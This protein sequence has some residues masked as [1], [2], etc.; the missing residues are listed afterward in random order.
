[1]LITPI[2]VNSLGGRFSNEGPNRV[3]IRA[4]HYSVKENRAVIFIFY[5]YGVHVII[6][7]HLKYKNYT[8]YCNRVIAFRSSVS[9]N[10]SSHVDQEWEE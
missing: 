5:S 2:L 3:R 7:K 8:I 4:R 6:F 9:Q 10:K 1:M